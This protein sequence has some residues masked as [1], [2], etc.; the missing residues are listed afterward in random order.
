MDDGRIFEMRAGDVFYVPPG[1]DSWV[2][3]DTPY[4]SLHFFGAGDYAAKS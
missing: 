3:G 1:H 4:V 2:L